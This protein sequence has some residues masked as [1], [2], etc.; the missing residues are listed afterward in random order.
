MTFFYPGITALSLLWVI[1]FWAVFTGIFE[2]AAAV[3]LRQ[4]LR[5]EWVL[6]LSGLL[7]VVFGVLVVAMR[8]P[9]LSRS[10]G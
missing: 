2:I 1:A 4:Q 5:N 9:E 7:S 8:A 6:L 3:K 10:S